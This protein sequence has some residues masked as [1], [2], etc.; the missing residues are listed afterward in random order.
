M[1]HFVKESCKKNGKECIYRKICGIGKRSWGESLLERIKTRVKKSW[2]K[3]GMMLDWFSISRVGRISTYIR[4][5]T[6]CHDQVGIDKWIFI[7]KSGWTVANNNNNTNFRY[8]SI[9]LERKNGLE[10][11]KGNASSG[12]ISKLYTHFI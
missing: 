10:T 1:K 5:K 4:R 6:G 3:L 7:V 2:R 11:G 9:Y 12:H 8:L